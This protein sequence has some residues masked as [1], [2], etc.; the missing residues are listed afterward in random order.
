[1]FCVKIFQTCYCLFLEP[2]HNEASHSLY[3]TDKKNNNGWRTYKK[4]PRWNKSPDLPIYRLWYFW[5]YTF[6]NKRF[7]KHW[8]ECP[9]LCFSQKLSKN[10][11]LGSHLDKV[12][13]AHLYFNIS[14]NWISPSLW[15]VFLVGG[16]L[17][18]II[19]LKV[20]YNRGPRHPRTTVQPSTPPS[21]SP[22]GPHLSHPRC[23]TSHPLKHFELS[24]SH[25]AMKY[26]TVLQLSVGHWN[27]ACDGGPTCLSKAIILNC[28]QQGNGGGGRCEKHFHETE[29]MSKFGSLKISISTLKV[30]RRLVM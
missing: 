2:S 19:W 26:W 21:N 28:L 10:R 9:N 7:Q 8:L 11:S 27:N 4:L 5:D 16:L 24:G 3:S 12:I 23:T 1:M 29:N 20:S 18:G 30:I 15:T 17:F 14:L 13:A 6:A 22:P 25:F